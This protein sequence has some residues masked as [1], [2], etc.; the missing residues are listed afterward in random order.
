M[1]NRL[2]VIAVLALVFAGTS[3]H[4]AGKGTYFSGNL[5]LSM[6]VDS[7]LSLSGVDF[8]EI[9]FDPGFNVGAAFGYDYGNAR[10]ELEIA[11][12]SWD[13][14]EATI[15]GGITGSIDGDASAL[16][17]MVNGYYDFHSTSSSLVPYLGA[18]IGLASVNVD[19]GLGADES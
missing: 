12:H 18:G 17:F 5:G 16:S 10:A 19:L 15:P 9:S 1:M 11:Y 7:E 8:L 4:A 3:A 13:M 14:D 2:I 6:A